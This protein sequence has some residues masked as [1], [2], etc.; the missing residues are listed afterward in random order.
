VES[1]IDDL[2][3]DFSSIL[4]GLFP[5]R[6]EKEKEDYRWA[7]YKTEVHAALRYIT[8][9]FQNLLDSDA[10]SLNKI[11]AA[12]LAV[13][14]SQQDANEAKRR[15]EE[16]LMSFPRVHLSTI[17]SSH[18]LPVEKEADEDDEDLAACLAAMKLRDGPQAKK[19]VVIFD[20][21]GCIPMYE[22]LGLSRLGRLIVCLVCVGDKNQL[23]PYDPGSSRNVFRR[24]AGGRNQQFIP[25]MPAETVK[26]LLDA[27]QL[28]V[29]GKIKLTTQ[30]RVPRDIA[31]LLDARI[32]KGD[33][34]TPLSCKVP[35]KGFNFVHVPVCHGRKKYVNENEI[36][37]C[38]EL[39]KNCLREGSDSIMV[40]TPVRLPEIKLDLFAIRLFI[41]KLTFFALVPLS[42]QYKKQQRE[43]Q[44]VFRR[45]GQK[46]E[47]IP[48]LTIDQC[49]GQEADIVII[50]LV[51]RPTRFLTKNR[52]NVALSRVRM[53]LFFLVDKGE[54]MAA[55]T[56]SSWE[57][58]LLAK[59]LLQLDGHY[60]AN[61]YF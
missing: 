60:T 22:F 57:C 26:S 27:S 17:G 28:T 35:L 39:A 32:Y 50:S 41:K 16:D 6:S 42:F 49:Q 19:T 25:T 20:E 31:N 21:A 37:K 43:L 15:I 56:N 47:A 34:V 11:E 13:R 38:L 58:S 12:Q 1:T 10:F 18:K 54:F 52:M 4:G 2:V 8:A 59:D 55:T 24:V 5:V 53:K 3:V 61:N 14:K 45:E 29:T 40:L 9:S 23:P 51:Q 7:S 30:Y 48:I 33:Y 44:F 36:R 46:F